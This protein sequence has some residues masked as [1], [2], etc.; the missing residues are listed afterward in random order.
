[1]PDKNEI[2]FQF[3]ADNSVDMISHAGLDRVLDYISPSCFH[4]L[5]WKPEEMTGRPIDEFILA[6][7]LPV[8]AA[9][10][11]SRSDT[12]ATRM[13]KKDGSIVWIESRARLVCDSVTGEPRQWVVVGRDITERKKCVPWR[14]P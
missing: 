3:L 1:V 13:L 14:L 6:D 5:G 8:L 2:D 12:S 10:I 4:I 7:D 9:A 11:A